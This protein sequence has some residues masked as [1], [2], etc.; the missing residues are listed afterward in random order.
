MLVPL[1]AR[2]ARRSLN[3]EIYVFSGSF[4]PAVEKQTSQFVWYTVKSDPVFCIL[5]DRGH[6]FYRYVSEG[7]KMCT[8]RRVPK[9]QG[10]EG[11]WPEIH[12]ENNDAL[13]NVH[14]APR[15]LDHLFNS[16]IHVRH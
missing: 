13:Y 1:L 3:C 8:R 11:L 16:W 7:E 2:L 15:K 9:R 14:V 4:G 12:E 10:G 6:I 5:A